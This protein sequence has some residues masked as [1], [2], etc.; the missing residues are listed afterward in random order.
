MALWYVDPSA[1]DDGNGGTGTGDAWATIQ[2]ALDNVTTAGD[3]VRLM[4]TATETPSAQVDL[5]TA[6]TG[7]WTSKITF[8]G[9]DGSGNALSAGSFYTI[10]GSSLPATT[11]LLSWG[12]TGLGDYLNFKNIR[13]TAATQHNLRIGPGSGLNFEVAAEFT[14]CR[15]DSA[16]SA[17]VYLGYGN[18]LSFVDCEIDSNGAEGCGPLT[19]GTNRGGHA[20]WTGCQ[21]HDNGSH[22]IVIAYAHNDVQG[23]LFYD[24][25]GDGIT[26]QRQ[27]KYNLVTHNTFHANDGSGI[28][29]GPSSPV[30]SF[31]MTIRYNSFH[32]NARYGIETYVAGDV[33]P[34]ISH[35]HYHS[36]TINE[37]FFTDGT[38]GAGNVLGDPLFTSTT[39]GSEDFTPLTGSTLIA[40][41]PNGE[42]YGAVAHADGGGGGTSMIG[43]GGGMIGAA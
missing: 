36:N 19:S 21:V 23:C 16:S 4:N 22:G 2:K 42:S 8:Q 3:E 29:P 35:N 32:L 30:G 15:I 26:Y 17:G 18:Y 5:D 1:G 28:G 11:D 6:N 33:Y 9:A 25:G 37:T 7:S 39:D 38:P 43:P 20:K 34:Y 24:N 31:L 10:S 13:F 40:V 14:E 41:G 27:G 12:T